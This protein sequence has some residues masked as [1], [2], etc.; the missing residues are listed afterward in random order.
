[1][2]D[3]IYLSLGEVEA[4]PHIR[5]EKNLKGRKVSLFSSDIVPYVSFDLLWFVNILYILELLLYV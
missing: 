4:D 3:F 2:L 1:M 5:Y